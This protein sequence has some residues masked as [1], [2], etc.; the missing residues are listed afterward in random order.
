MNR[1]I[2]IALTLLV[3]LMWVPASAQDDEEELPAVAAYL[4]LEGGLAMF[5]SAG[6]RADFPLGFQLAFGA[7]LATGRDLRIR[8][9]PQLGVRFFTKDVEQDTNEHFR[10]FRVGSTFGYDAYFIG[11][12][13]FFPYVTVNYNWVNNYE[14]ETTGYDWEGNPTVVYSDSFIKGNGVSAELGLKVQIRSFFVK[15][16]FDVF[17]P[18]L[19]VRYEEEVE[20]PDRDRPILQTRYRNESFN[21]NAFSLSIGYILF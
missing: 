12:T 5:Q 1:V 21:L 15:G 11:Q 18:S 9:R 14:A 7:E 19:R 4:E 16:G 6:M 8:L 20:Q 2:V 13:S 3:W 17:Q 10:L